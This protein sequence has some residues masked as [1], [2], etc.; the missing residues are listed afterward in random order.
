MFVSRVF[1]E[2]SRDVKFD[3]DFTV[4]IEE[5]CVPSQVIKNSVFNPGNYRGVRMT[6]QLAKVVERLLGPLFIPQLC[7][8]AGNGPNQCAYCKERGSRDA[9]A[10]IMLSCGYFVGCKKTFPAKLYFIN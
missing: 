5:S 2:N 8:V 1:Y 4:V 10:Y 3:K 6:A 9:L 7:C